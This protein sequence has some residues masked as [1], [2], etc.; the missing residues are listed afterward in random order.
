MDFIRDHPLIRTSM[1]S[2][3]GWPT[4]LDI[5][6]FGNIHLDIA[7]IDYNTHLDIALIIRG[8]ERRK[9]P[10]GNTHLDIA[11]ISNTHLDIALI[12]HNTDLDIALIALLSSGSSSLPGLMLMVW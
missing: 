1:K 8:A 6:L 4:D 12:N 2:N 10:N 9:S 7:L 5:A 3:T 11:L